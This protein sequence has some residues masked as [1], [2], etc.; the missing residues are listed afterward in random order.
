MGANVYLNG[1]ILPAESAKIG[2]NDRGFLFGDGLI[3]SFR[4]YKQAPFMLK[5]H[6]NRLEQ[7][8]KAVGINLP[9]IE[10]L[11]QA[12]YKVIESN[13]IA[14]G[15]IRI[16]VTRG[17]SVN[18]AL[19]EDVASPNILITV[20]DL[21]AGGNFSSEQ[22]GVKA[23]S[24]EDKRSLVSEHKNSSMLASIV[25]YRQALER[26]AFDMIQITRRGFVTEGLRSNVFIVL[27]G[28]LLTPPVSKRVL[29]GITRQIVINM[30]QRNGIKVEE[31][32][33][34]GQD[35]PDAEEIFLT[36][37][38]REI[39]PITTLN[40]AP[41]ASGQVGKITNTLQKG[42]KMLVNS[43]LDKMNVVVS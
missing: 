20:E 38:I 35:L 29:P 37:S 42:Y 31:D 7:S 18:N 9:D 8:A 14:E 22:A 15:K 12:T 19:Y 4:T 32:A 33:I 27:D 41:I 26:G 16:T 43:W 2:I 17:N 5:S 25:S 24:G 40:N 13:N 6:L 1:Q 21:N 3:E 23:I 10:E 39:V 36:N 30:A 28:I 34:V 11:K